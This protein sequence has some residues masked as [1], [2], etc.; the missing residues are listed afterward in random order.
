MGEWER[1]RG[2]V[3]E[4]ETEWDRKREREREN[5]FPI[6]IIYFSNS[7]INCIFLEQ[8]QVQGLVK[9]GHLREP[10]Y[11]HL[12]YSPSIIYRDVEQ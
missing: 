10:R 8:P 9:M 7:N 11:L 6:K 12:Y 2:R 3:G 5:G 4:K 1:K